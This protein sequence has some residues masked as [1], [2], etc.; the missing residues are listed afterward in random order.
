MRGSIRLLSMS[1]QP[2]CFLDLPRDVRLIVYEHLTPT[3]FQEVFETSLLQP[4]VS[5]STTLREV[6][7]T[8]VLHPNFSSTTSHVDQTRN[9]KVVMTRKSLSSAILRVCKLIYDEAAPM[10][11]KQREEVLHAPVRW[12]IEPKD[13]NA[14]LPYLTQLMP[15][16]PSPHESSFDKIILARCRRLFAE[17][18]ARGIRNVQIVIEPPR[19]QDAKTEYKDMP[20]KRILVTLNG[21]EMTFGYQGAEPGEV[22][23]LFGNP[24]QSVHEYEYKL[25]NMEASEWE[26]WENEWLCQYMVVVHTALDMPNSTTMEDRRRQHDA[27]VM[28]TYSLSWVCNC[29]LAM[30]GRI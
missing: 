3:T 6:F 14:L 7:E 9:T 2:F 25:K 21:D 22:T 13:C 23:F 28:E 10:L 15:T 16:H 19:S 1:G 27:G 18:Q 4:A 24:G 29:I 17:K 11:S 8:N 20:D 12:T 5:S 26:E 30:C